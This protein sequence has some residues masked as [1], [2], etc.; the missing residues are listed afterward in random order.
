MLYLSLR[1]V[2]ITFMALWIASGGFAGSD[3]RRTLATGDPAQVPLLRVRMQRFAILGGVSSL[4]TILTGIALIFALGGF[5]KV[6]VAIHVG[7]TLGVILGIVGGAGIG[8]T[9][10]KID[11]LLGPAGAPS[12]PS[13]V[14]ALV[15]RLS[16]HTGIF[17]LLWLTTLVLMVFRTVL[18]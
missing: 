5:G 9:W 4:V 3:V 2:H 18:F 1:F 12:D 6:P 10:R 17:H 16:M 11:A 14:A 8:G 15:K 7:L 13:A